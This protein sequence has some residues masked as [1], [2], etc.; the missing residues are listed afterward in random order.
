MGGG[1]AQVGDLVEVVGVPL[2]MGSAPEDE[3]GSANP[4]LELGDV[5][6][7]NRVTPD[8]GGGLPWTGTVASSAGADN[9]LQGTI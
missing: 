1:G 2:T 7:R 5:L 8:L 6:L 3:A 4:G 9:E